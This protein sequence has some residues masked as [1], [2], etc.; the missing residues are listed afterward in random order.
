MMHRQTV[1]LVVHPIPHLGALPGD[2]LIV[3]PTD[4]D[5]PL[6]IMREFAA[7]ML[8]TFSGRAV[9]KISVTNE[10]DE[11]PGPRLRLV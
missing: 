10:D 2:E 8:G 11:T 9:R 4:P 1:Y 5:F 6:T 3:R 7:E